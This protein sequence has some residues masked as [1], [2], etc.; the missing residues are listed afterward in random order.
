MDLF[1]TSH[2]A[3]HAR[4]KEHREGEE[5]KTKHLCERVRTN[6]DIESCNWVLKPVFSILQT[7]EGGKTPS[8]G[9]IVENLKNHEEKPKGTYEPTAAALINWHTR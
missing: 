5:V 8:A 2:F 9:R 7:L 4:M 6:A 3:Y 1:A